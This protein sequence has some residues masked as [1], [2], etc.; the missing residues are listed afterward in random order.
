MAPIVGALPGGKMYGTSYNFTNANYSVATVDL[1]GNVTSIYQFSQP[2]VP[3][4][5]IFSAD[6]NY[7]GMAF[8]YLGTYAYRLTPSGVLTQIATLPFITTGLP[9]SG[10]LLQGSDGNFYGIQTNSLGCSS[11]HGA[12]FKLTPA[13]QFTVLHDFG[14]EEVT[15]LI[16]G[17]DGKLY[18]ATQNYGVLFSITKSGVYKAEYQLNGLNGACTCYLLQGS[19]GLIYGAATGGGSTGAGVIF[20][21]DAGLPIPKPKA[22][23][24]SPQSGAVGTKVLIWGANLFGATVS[25]NGVAATKAVNAGPFYFWATVPT[26]ATTGP[27]TVT[28]PGGTVTAHGSF[29]VQ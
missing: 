27:L 21:L 13:G 26:G 28:T 19:D 15:S 6:G 5:P 10:V 29:T 25:F 14:C 4:H 11:Q 1:N 22:L 3:G 23:R 24:F 16:E 8:S 9:G 12:V 17:S 18:G 20:A 7:Y 2:D